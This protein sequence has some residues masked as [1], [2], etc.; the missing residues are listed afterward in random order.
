MGIV[1]NIFILLVIG[2]SMVCYAQ[3]GKDSEPAVLEAQD[4]ITAI[5]REVQQGTFPEVE[6]KLWSA[7]EGEWYGAPR[8]TESGRKTAGF[9]VDPDNVR[10]FAAYYLQPGDVVSLK[11][12]Q[13]RRG[14]THIVWEIQDIERLPQGTQVATPASGHDLIGAVDA[15]VGSHAQGVPVPITF[16]VRNVSRETMALT[17]PSGQLY[18]FVV[19]QDEDPVWHWS[20]GRFFT[21]ALQTR[22]L[23]AGEEW[24]FSEEWDQTLDD[25]RQAESGVYKIVASLTT[26]G[27]DKA[28]TMAIFEIE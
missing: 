7:E 4:K 13:A 24:V 15:G 26:S 9:F 17:F 22:S 5:V 25:G 10:H 19:Y 12:V 3:E 11:R 14:V 28:E 6:L 27:E 18:E 21:Q 23:K 20:R 8:Y 2:S 1:T 16:T